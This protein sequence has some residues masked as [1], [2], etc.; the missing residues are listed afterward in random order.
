MKD[1][2]PTCKFIGILL[3]PLLLL[4][5]YSPVLNLLVFLISLAAVLLGKCNRKALAAAMI[6]I[7]LSALALFFTGMH[8]PSD[9]HLALHYDLFAG[10]AVWNRL[11]LSSFQSGVVSR[12]AVKLRRKSASS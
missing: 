3:P 6:P 7:F 11:Q 8:F 12:P 9:S 1:L 2:N 10:S 4:F 5:F